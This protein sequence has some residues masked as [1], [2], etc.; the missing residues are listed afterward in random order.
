M[1]ETFDAQLVHALNHGRRWVILLGVTL[2]A[3]LEVLDTTIVNVPL[4]QMAGNLG[5]TIQDIAWVSTGYI[6][7]NVV[8]LPMTA[9]LTVRF[10]RRNYLT[11]SILI[12]TIS[13]FMCGMGN[14]LGELVFWRILQGAA[15]AALISTAQAV[16]IQVFPPQEQGIVQPLFF[17]G[18]VVAPTVGPALGGY[19]T[20]ALSW[21]WC[22]FI[23]VP[24][25][26]IAAILIYASLH[27][28]EPARA[29]EHVDWPGIALLTAG[30]GT[31]QYILEEGERDD[32]F[33]SDV[34]VRL[35]MLSGAAIV[36][37]V[38]WLLSD[39]NRKP[40]IDLRILRNP[41]LLAGMSLF[42]AT[43]VGLYGVTF[44]YPLLAQSLEGM[45]S[46]QTGMALLPGGLATAISIVGCASIINQPG[47]K[48]DGR[49]LVMA[50]MGALIFAMWE[51]GQLNAGA[52]NDNTFWPLLIRGASIGLVII[53][54]NGAAIASLKPADVGQGAALLALGRQLGGSFGIAV[55]ATFLNS[56]VRINR[57][58]LVDNINA[59]SP[60]LHNRLAE[61]TAGVVQHG[62][63]LFAAQQS[64]LA[65]VDQSLMQQAMAK[66]F[67]ETFLLL[68]AVSVATAPA[69]FL[70]RK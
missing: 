1:A 32:W 49:A 34:I 3:I 50:G 9:F 16:L 7:S 21:R 59:A 15:G 11:A 61:L 66:S 38:L 46:Q 17:L 14:S 31:L 48:V 36:A 24:L 65:I 22:F 55:L 12:F 64:A 18:I 52:G 33:Q 23:N 28:T 30:L 35:S 51:M 40:V 39:K 67:N 70:L 53:P 42:A 2:A 20:D 27:D 13:S 6:L 45:T 19:L 37:L 63:S 43:G 68:L 58:Y 29:D 56:H 57:A 69:I 25:G 10:G 26:I 60:I 44:L 47:N 62:Q 41:S 8:V 5:T 54:I 4:P